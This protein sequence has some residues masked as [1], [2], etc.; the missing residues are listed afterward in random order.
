M[1]TRISISYSLQRLQ[2]LE[3]CPAQ[4][5]KLNNLF[6]EVRDEGVSEI[7]D[8]FIKRLVSLKPHSLQPALGYDSELSSKQLCLDTLLGY[9]CFVIVVEILLK[10]WDVGQ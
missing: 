9:L 6:M 2:C 7:P 1:R 4:S 10:E 3:Q 8:L 5:S